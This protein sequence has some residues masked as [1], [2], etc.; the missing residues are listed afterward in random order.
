MKGE[1]L[2]CDVLLDVPEPKDSQRTNRGRGWWWNVVIATL[3]LCS[4][5]VK[6]NMQF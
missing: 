1:D 2:T 6:V 5:A 4:I 3:L